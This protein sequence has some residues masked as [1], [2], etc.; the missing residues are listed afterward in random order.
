MG[1]TSLVGKVG[2]H[3]R[4]GGRDFGNA[5]MNDDEDWIGQA[6]DDSTIVPWFIVTLLGG[7][8]TIGALLMA[9]VY[10]FPVTMGIFP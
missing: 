1:R 9:Y 6:G 10:L 7:V 4:R 3:D 2:L 8:L 5:L